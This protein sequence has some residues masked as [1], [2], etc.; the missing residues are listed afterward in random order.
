MSCLQGKT[1]C[2]GDAARAAFP[3]KLRIE[4]SKFSLRAGY[5]FRMAV[6]WMSC[7]TTGMSDLDPVEST[8][9]NNYDIRDRLAAVLHDLWRSQMAR[10][11]WQLHTQ[12]NAP[13]KH[14][15]ALVPF[16]ELPEE[17]RG[18]L[19]LAIECEEWEQRM[20]QYIARDPLRFF[21]R[22]PTRPFARGE[23]RVGTRVRYL[24]E[25]GTEGCVVSWTSGADGRPDSIRVRWS[26]GEEVDYANQEQCLARVEQSD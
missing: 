3:G 25:P 20:V 1:A 7:S 14:H 15:D 24:Y 8:T 2:P 10:A 13:R 19:R 12:H 6:H 18:Q 22:G 9:S 5:L 16:D 23:L 11:G 4:P 17:D 21:P 26:D